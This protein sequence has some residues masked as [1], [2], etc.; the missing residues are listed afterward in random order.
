MRTHFSVAEYKK[1][2]RRPK[3][4]PGQKLT[5]E[6]RTDEG[7]NAVARSVANNLGYFEVHS[8]GSIYTQNI[9]GISGFNYLTNAHAFIG[10]VEVPDAKLVF[11]RPNSTVV[12]R[13]S[14]VK[15]T[16]MD[17]DKVM[18]FHTALPMCRNIVKHFQLRSDLPTESG[19]I[20]TPIMFYSREH[21]RLL[22]NGMAPLLKQRASMFEYSTT[23]TT[24]H[25]GGVP[26]AHYLEGYYECPIETGAGD[27]GGFYTQLNSVAQ[28]KI[29]GI[30]AG[31]FGP[32]R[33]VVVPVTQEE[34]EDALTKHHASSIGGD[35]LLEAQS[36]IRFDD[37]EVYDELYD[38]VP[39][40]FFLMG[41][42]KNPLHMNRVSKILPSPMENHRDAITAPPH[43]V[44]WINDQGK[45]VVPE[46][47]FFNKGQEFADIDPDIVRR[48]SIG[49]EYLVPKPHIAMT[50]PVL[51][52][53]Q[54]L[55][56]VPNSMCG[57]IRHDTSAGYRL[58]KIC[59]KGKQPYL[60]V[61][62][63]DSG[64]HIT[65]SRIAK[66]DLA[67]RIEY[68][69]QGVP[70]SCFSDSQKDERYPLSKPEKYRVVSTDDV[71]DLIITKQYFGVFAEALRRNQP[72]GKSQVGIDATGPA[73]HFLYRYLRELSNNVIALDG[74]AWDFILPYIIRCVF[75]EIAERWYALHFPLDEEAR[76]IRR[77]IA[78]KYVVHVHLF[79]RLVL[80]RVG[81]MP[82]GYYLTGDENGL[83]N[84]LCSKTIF[85]GVT[86][87]TNFD[88]HV[89]SAYYG[90]DMIAVVK[91]CETFNQISFAIWAKQFLGMT[92]TTDNKVAPT[93]PYT[94][95]DDA[96]FIS[97]WF[98]RVD[99][100]DVRIGALEIESIK[101]IAMWTKAT[102]PNQETSMFRQNCEMS[103]R[104]M[105][106]HGRMAF[107]QWL[108]FCNKVLLIECNSPPITLSYDGLRLE[109]LN[110][111]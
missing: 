28:R 85:T 107:N 110:K 66:A 42:S 40:G 8:N 62:V 49:E 46:S 72:L 56:G 82:S 101:E 3:K 22:E 58:R 67:K 93:D 90:D 77:H 25:I 19:V 12:V 24:Q 31:S 27:C 2:P 57:P 33:A 88:E 84:R 96:S 60:H 50:S 111:L 81:G 7:A 95:L 17:H 92:W 1:E 15:I 20:P 39:R 74:K 97:R 9:L 109:W 4:R 10:T 105:F 83:D 47:Y 54:V 32:A 29:L 68:F 18:V 86:G 100:S 14:E 89:R 91:S 11:W 23:K 44:P 71:A 34:L 94:N 26:T 104:E 75:Y 13:L 98:K 99:D 61:N 35:S 80:I 106:P 41:L 45:R 55:N 37:S 43:M 65:L 52:M 48:A 51:T 69:K 30:H 21:D 38:N 36:G 6:I 103:L 53:D 59:K 76:T 16:Q 5:A 87:Q 79:G 108:A 63:T 78:Q 73:F 64:N 70:F 102:D